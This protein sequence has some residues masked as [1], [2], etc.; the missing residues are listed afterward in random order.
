MHAD[1]LQIMVETIYLPFHLCVVSDFHLTAFLTKVNSSVNSCVGIP[2]YAHSNVH[3]LFE[4]I[5]S[6]FFVEFDSELQLQIYR[7]SIKNPRFFFKEKL[8]LS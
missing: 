3:V 4:Q 8:N 6:L 7:Q 5:I 2:E 1:D